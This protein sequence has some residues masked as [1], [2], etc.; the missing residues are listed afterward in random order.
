MFDN[1]E[2]WTYECPSAP[3]TP[4]APPD[5]ALH[6]LVHRHEHQDAVDVAVA[7]DEVIVTNGSTR[8]VVGRWTMWPTG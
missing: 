6:Q 1:L 3:W 7:G 2:L 5:A 8:P 4:T